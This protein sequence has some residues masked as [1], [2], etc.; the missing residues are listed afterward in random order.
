VPNH[1]RPA[2]RCSYFE[3]KTVECTRPYS[4]L[5]VSISYLPGM[6]RDR[7]R[8][9]DTADKKRTRRSGA[10]GRSAAIA[11]IVCDLPRSGFGT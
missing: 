4:D 10:V 1:R 3:E 7:C 9:I 5:A 8:N 2:R 11:F 6:H